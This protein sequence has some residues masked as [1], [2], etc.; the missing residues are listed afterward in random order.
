MTLI[1]TVLFQT[2][3]MA[4]ERRWGGQLIEVP[5]QSHNPRHLLRY[6]MVVDGQLKDVLQIGWSSAGVRV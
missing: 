4:R 5:P 1:T 6:K 3:V 2:A